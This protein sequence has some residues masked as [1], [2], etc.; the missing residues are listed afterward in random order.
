MIGGRQVH[1]ASKA[2]MIAPQPS[3]FTAQAATHPGLAHTL[4]YYEWPARARVGARVL[5]CVHGL[6]RNALDFAVLAPAFAD[7]WRVIA[8]DMPG[9]G[10]S[11]WLKDPADYNYTTYIADLTALLDHLAAGQV[12][13]V[14]TSM[15]GIIGMM[16]AG[17]LP[18]RIGRLMLND[19]GAA[20]PAAG[21]R[22][23]L[24]YAGRNLRY[25]SRAEAERALRSNCAPFGIRSEANWQRLFSSSLVDED[26]GS[27][28]IAYD[29]AVVASFPSAEDVKDIDFSPVWE[30]VKCP[31]LILRGAESDILTGETARMMCEGKSG[32]T[33]VELPGVGHAPSLMEPDQIAPIARWLA[34][35]PLGP[36]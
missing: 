8:V 2:A 10:K 23:I 25:E 1:L 30:G 34:A 21:L 7:R 6:M 13:W 5:F 12:D 28:R 17:L 26:D 3:F 22:R 36:G 16:M 32:V 11:D 19:I 20:I 15:G 31:T 33:L 24:S 14:G 4:A 29:P 27:T 18:D 35:T 9:R